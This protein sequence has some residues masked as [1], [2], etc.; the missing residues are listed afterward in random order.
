[1]WVAPRVSHFA[2]HQSRSSPASSVIRFCIAE[3]I[4]E[5]AEVVLVRAP[6]YRPDYNLEVQ[7]EIPSVPLVA[8]FIT[9]VE[10][11][12]RRQPVRRTTITDRATLRVVR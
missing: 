5:A 7:M 4:G 6:A 10:P 2:V 1:M 12:E 11:S 9:T 8:R 3:R